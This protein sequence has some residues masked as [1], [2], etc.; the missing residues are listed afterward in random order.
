MAKIRHS[1]LYQLAGFIVLTNP[2]VNF[3]QLQSV[4]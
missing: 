3:L 2:V 1:C 4:L